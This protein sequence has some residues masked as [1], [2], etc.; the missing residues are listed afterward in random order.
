[1][2]E[3]LIIK[4]SRGREKLIHPSTKAAIS[5]IYALEME[6]GMFHALDIG[7]GSGILAMMMARK[8]PM[9]EI[10]ASDISKLAVD[11]ARENVI[12]NGFAEQITCYQA[13]GLD[14]P[15]IKQ[16][17]PYRL[18]V[19]NLIAKFHVQYIAEIE[20][21]LAEDGAVILSGILAWRL[22]EIEQALVFTALSIIEK[23]EL[24]GWTALKLRKN[25]DKK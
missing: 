15:Q 20:R 18:I 21:M 12:E 10:I 3:S 5:L 11:E 2:T 4:D 14:H 13:E 23:I 8:W 9:A 19:A 16:H 7:T 25:I 6:V 24:E 22:Q 17:A 1:M